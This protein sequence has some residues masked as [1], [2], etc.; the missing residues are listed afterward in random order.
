V[1]PDE[2]FYAQPA[3]LQQRARRHRPPQILIDLCVREWC[4]CNGVVVNRLLIFRQQLDG[5][6]TVPTDRLQQCKGF[7][8]TCLEFA[9]KAVSNWLAVGQ[10]VVKEVQY[11]SPFKRR[12]ANGERQRQ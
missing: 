4:A 7:G 8:G 2:A 5:A 3:P 9:C 11:P 12:I 10:Q 6:H 1:L